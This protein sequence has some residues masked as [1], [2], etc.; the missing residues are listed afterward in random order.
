MVAGRHAEAEHLLE[1]YKKGMKGQICVEEEMKD[2]YLVVEV[3]SKIPQV[4]SRR[5][6]KG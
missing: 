6:G 1:V 4:E 5:S 2:N 3:L